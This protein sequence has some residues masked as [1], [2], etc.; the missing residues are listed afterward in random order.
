M[1]AA[2]GDV[3]GAAVGDDVGD[4]VGEAVGAADGEAVGAADGETVGAAE[5]EDVGDDVGEA[6]GA[7][8]G[9]VECDDVGDAV[10]EA[11]GETLGAPVGAAVCS[12]FL[13]SGHGAQKTRLPVHGPLYLLH[14]PAMPPWH[15]RLHGS[16]LVPATSYTE[17][18]GHVHVPP[19][20]PSALGAGLSTDPEY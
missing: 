6:V 16:A 8:D 5:G 20:L 4:E 2:V 15:C 3:V 11:E 18:S 14:L 7:A 17:P 1:G 10:G 9:A 12:G 13:K 19:H